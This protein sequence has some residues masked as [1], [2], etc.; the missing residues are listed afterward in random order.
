MG[1]SKVAG[2]MYVLNRD[3]LY[4]DPLTLE[5]G[6]NMKMGKSTTTCFFQILVCWAW[7]YPFM[8]TL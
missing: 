4:S 8:N 5:T 2:L 3:D 6:K 7:I 1:L